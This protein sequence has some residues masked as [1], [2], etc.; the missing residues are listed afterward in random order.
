MKYYQVNGVRFGLST[1][2]SEFFENNIEKYEIE[3]CEVEHLIETVI[4]ESI[5]TKE[6]LPDFKMKNREVYVEGDTEIVF[7][8]DKGFPVLK[9]ETDAK[10]KQS[11]VT[12]VDDIDGASELEYVYTGILFMELC[13]YHSIQSIHGSAVAFNNQA[14]VFSGPS[15]TGKTTH[16]EYWKEIVS[17]LVVINDDK[18]L[19][20]KKGE[21]IMVSGS[22]WSGKTKENTNLSLSLHS[23]VFLEQGESNVI[24]ELS[25]NEKVIQIM[26]NINRPRQDEL[27]DNVSD[28]I[29]LLIDVIPMYKATVSNGIEAAIAVK[30]KLGV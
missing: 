25:K 24:K 16:V 26:R 12:M 22:P 9:I 21:K 10:Y 13:L 11:V 23:I 5:H 3:P 30:K 19:L 6:V 2:T 17:D 8:Y 28:T 1:V 29:E 14:I 7:I 15:G 27:W 20:S 18:P 4:V